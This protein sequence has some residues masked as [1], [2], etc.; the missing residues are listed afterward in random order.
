MAIEGERVN[1]DQTAETAV[2][3]PSSNSLWSNNRDWYLTFIDGQYHTDT[4]LDDLSFEYVAQRNGNYDLVDGKYVRVENGKGSYVK[5]FTATIKYVVIDYYSFYEYRDSTS[6]SSFLLWGPTKKE[7]AQLHL[8][9][10]ALD[11][12]IESS[13]TYSVTWTEGQR[14]ANDGTLNTYGDLIKVNETVSSSILT[15]VETSY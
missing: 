1:I 5:K 10:N 13:I 7:L 14:A 4:D 15:K 2:S 9:G 3:L 11:F 8:D 12:L 6:T